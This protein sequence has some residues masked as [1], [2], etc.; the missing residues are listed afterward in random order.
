MMNVDKLI[1]LVKR[2]PDFLKLM[3]G[4]K[5]FYKNT[6]DKDVDKIRDLKKFTYNF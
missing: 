4:S 2:N 1:R 3:P 6:N 5:L